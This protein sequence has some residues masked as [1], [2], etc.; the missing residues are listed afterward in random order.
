MTRPATAGPATPAAPSVP[1]ATDHEPF[2]GA[3]VPVAGERAPRAVPEWAYGVAGVASLLLVWAA[4]SGLGLVDANSLPPPTDVLGRLL[5]LLTSGSFLLELGST[6]WAWLLAML[7]GTAVAVPV[8][9]LMGYSAQ[10]HRS[11]STVVN[12]ARAVP[13]AA[14]LPVA[15]LLF[16]LD[17]EM[18]VSLAFYALVWPVLLNAMYGVRDADP[19]MLGVGRSMGW[20]RTRL[21]RRVVLPAAA[22]SIATG[23]RVASS[24]ALVVV[25]STELLGATSGVGTV[26]TR[27]GQTQQPDFVYAGILVIG[28]L[29]MAL[30][31]GLHGVERLLLPWAQANRGAR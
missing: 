18:K 21:L 13:S 5:T 30:Y 12:A 26:I 20:G 8:G 2:A 6:L 4:V 10:L 16:G 28:L 14:L 25:L 19:V 22:P 7:L 17:T 11:A 24:I 29:G 1:P 9:L 23:I 15:I 27:Y 3:G 31:Y